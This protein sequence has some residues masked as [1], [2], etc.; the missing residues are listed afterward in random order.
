M[1]DE[2][3][4]EV[5]ASLNVRLHDVEKSL[6]EL[7]SERQKKQVQLQASIEIEQRLQSIEQLGEAF[8][9]ALKSPDAR[10]PKLRR[11]TIDTLDIRVKI[12][13]D[14][15]KFLALLNVFGVSIQIY[16]H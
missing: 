10:L 5:I 16:I 4:N 14:N 6:T 2:Q 11:A 7:R 8:Q 9:D 12:V 13:R 3:K 1:P 15:D